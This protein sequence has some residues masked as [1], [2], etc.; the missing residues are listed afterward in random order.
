[1]LEPKEVEQLENRY[2][3]EFYY[4]LKFAKRRILIGF[5]TKDKIKDQWINKWGGEKSD[6]STGA[7][8]IIYAF[9]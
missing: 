7:E 5:D 9:F 2:L 1:M 8:R 6:F 3:D 4:F